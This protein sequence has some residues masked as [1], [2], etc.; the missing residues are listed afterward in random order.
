MHRMG[1]CW[2]LPGRTDW[3]RLRTDVMNELTYF[4]YILEIQVY[5]VAGA[6]VIAAPSSRHTTARQG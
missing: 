3:V 6:W 1:T 4:I 2:D 5:V